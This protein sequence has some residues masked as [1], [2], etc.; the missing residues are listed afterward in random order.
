[1]NF[2]GSAL[3][4]VPIMPLPIMTAGKW[5]PRI[6]PGTPLRPVIHRYP[7]GLII[8]LRAPPPII[9]PPKYRPIMDR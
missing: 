4:P 6:Q 8:Q 9:D 7:A 2:P 5:P 1:M 3:V